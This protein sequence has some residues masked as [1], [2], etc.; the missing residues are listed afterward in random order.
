MISDTS[1]NTAS[2]DVY[3]PSAQN[4]WN[5]SKIHHL[6]RRVAFG[7]TK[8]QVKAAL[9]SDPETL[10]D[11]LIDQAIA[12]VPSPEP[13]WGFWDKDQ[14]DAAEMANEDNNLVFYRNE[15]KKQMLSDFWQHGLRDRLT[16][17]WSNH[18]VTEDEVYASPAYQYQYYNLLQFHTLGNFKQFTYDIGIAAPML[19]YLNGDQNTK[20]RPNENYARELYE[21][22]T[23][24]VDN[25]Y[26]ENDILETAKAIT[27]WVE[28]NDIPWGPITFDASK[29]ST[30]SKNIFGQNGNWDYDDVIDIL[31]TQRQNRIANFICTKL[32]TYFVSPTCNDAIINQM[33]QTFIDGNFE[34]APVLRQLFK[35]EHFFDPEAIGAIIKSPVDVIVNFY[36]EMNFS[37]PTDFDINDFTINTVRVLGQNLLSPIDVEGWQGDEEWISPDVLIGRWESIR[38]L[39]GRAWMED[40]EQFR[41]FILGLPIGTAA[42]GEIDTTMQADEVTVVVKA[43]LDYF[44]PRGLQ[45]PTLFNEAVEI[46]KGDIYPSNYY[47]PDAIA[48]NI[49]TLDLGGA[50]NQF[51]ALLSHIAEIPE[52]HLK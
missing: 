17:F 23:L 2:L 12:L 30:D 25:G 38:V 21:L 14:F 1:C 34:I 44:L 27:G 10:I 49:W 45:D 46:F 22:F 8:N 19:V 51:L 52:F 7:A 5:V 41:D 37:I 9:N 48:P 4:P 16:L 31:F 47:E 29:F 50:P 13:L 3:I 20:D 15:G 40:T 39:L 33:A 43:I 26:T 6:Y 35:S 24:G 28:K 32:Y 18:F 36:K 11:T 42:D